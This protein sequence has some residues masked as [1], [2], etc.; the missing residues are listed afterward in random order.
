MGTSNEKDDP[1]GVFGI[2]HINEYG[3][4]FRSYLSMNNLCAMSTRFLKKEYA[5]WIHPRRKQKHQIDHFLVNREMSH[6]IMDSGITSCLL[7]SDHQALSIKVRVMKRLRKRVIM[8]LRQK[9]FQL[10]LSGLSDSVNRN[11]FC[12]DV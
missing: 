10:D 9:M 5:T 12:H 2:A 4:R 11:K 7:D 3:R 8:E 6:R 1:I